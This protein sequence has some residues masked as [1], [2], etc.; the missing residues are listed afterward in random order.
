MANETISRCVIT[1]LRAAFKDLK[2]P[3]VRKRHL[4]TE[5]MLHT[6]DLF[7]RVLRRVQQSMKK[8]L[9]PL[10]NT[11]KN[12][13][14]MTT[15]LQTLDE[16]DRFIV[17]APKLQAPTPSALFGET[18]SVPKIEEDEIFDEDIEEALEG[19]F[20][21]DLGGGLEDDFIALAGGVIEP[22][23]KTLTQ[24]RQPNVH[25]ENDSND[26]SDFDDYNYDGSD[27]GVEEEWDQNALHC[28]APR[29][30]IDE[31]FDQL[32]E[33]DYHYDQLGE[34]DG[35]DHLVGGVLEPTDE[36][37]KRMIKESNRGPVDDEEASKEWTRQRMRLVEANV[38]KDDTMEN[39][40]S[41]YFQID[42]SSSKR[43]KWDCES[44]ATQCTN[45]Y[46]RPTLIQN[47]KSGKL[48]R[49]ALK[50][51]D[52]AAQ[53]IDDTEV[54]DMETC[55]DDNMSQCSKVSTYRPKSE[56]SEQRRLRKQAIKETRRQRRQEKKGNKL[57]FAE[58]H[59]K[60]ARER[61]GQIK[62]IPIV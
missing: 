62:T 17:R 58:E 35:G 36:R 45:I 26:D 20:D 24:H 8:G 41:I 49:R 27:N 50:S 29:R 46:N 42:E 34:L 43:L 5:R 22:M 32:L 6:T 44:Y 40:I 28:N 11:W 25:Y 53:E 15:T 2:I 52:R 4:W 3:W 56:T 12:N 54:C 55:L 19:N 13:I 33:A 47:P 10:R 48:S 37:V 59:R 31:R 21:G 14:N 30:E 39:I 51:L 61:V 57:A 60:I 7:L 23:S 16:K 18:K 38:V 1:W 9:F